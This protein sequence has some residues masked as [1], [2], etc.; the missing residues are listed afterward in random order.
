MDPC[1][2]PGCNGRYYVTENGRVVSR[3]K[4][5]KGKRFYRELALKPSKHRRTGHLRVCL[6]NSESQRSHFYIHVL[7]AEAF[8]G[9]RPYGALV[10]HGDGNPRNNSASN[11]RWGTTKDNAQDREWHRKERI[12]LNEDWWTDACARFEAR[13]SSGETFA[14][15]DLD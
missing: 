12:F 15:L 3:W 4:D 8:L 1:T 14:G 6:T 7:V 13:R 5:S 10:L 11:L 9:D 2:I